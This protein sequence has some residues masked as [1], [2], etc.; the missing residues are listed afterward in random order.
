LIEKGTGDD[1][2]E[3]LY[4][5]SDDEEEKGRDRDEEDFQEEF[6]DIDKS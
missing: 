6:D 1:L 2:D 5:N 4:D 3:R